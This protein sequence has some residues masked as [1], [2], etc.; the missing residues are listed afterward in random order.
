[1]TEYT[2]D[3]IETLIVKMRNDGMMPSQIGM[4]L[5]DQYGIPSVKE[6][7]DKTITEILED[8]DAGLRLPEDLRSLIVNAVELREHLEENPKDVSAKKGLQEKEA[9]IRSLGRY[10]AENGAIDPEIGRAHV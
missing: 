4:Q 5:R 6:E 2:E 1:M 10:Y 7:T 8:N 3:E 9:H